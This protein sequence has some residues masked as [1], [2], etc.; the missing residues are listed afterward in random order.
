M[1][2]YKVIVF[3]PRENE[4]TEVEMSVNHRSHIP[5]MITQK[6]GKVKIVSVEQI[7]TCEACLLGS[8]GLSDHMYPGGCSYDPDY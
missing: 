4:T 3:N 1:E 2:T 5:E 8:L 6:L 7:V